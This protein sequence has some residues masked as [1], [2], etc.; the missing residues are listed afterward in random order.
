MLKNKIGILT[1]TF[2]SFLLGNSCVD[3]HLNMFKRPITYLEFSSSTS[4]LEVLAHKYKESVFIFWGN[5]NHPITYADNEIHLTEE[6]TPE[7][8]Q[9]LGECEHID[10][11]FINI[12]KYLSNEQWLKS[13][14]L[15][16]EHVFIEIETNKALQTLLI[17]FGFNEINKQEAK[18]TYYKYNKI[19]FLKRTQWLEPASLSNSIREIKSSYTEKFLIKKYAQYPKPINWLSGINLMTFKMLKGTYPT[20]DM[21]S[22]EMAKTYDIHHLDWMPNNIIVRGKHMQ[23]IDTDDSNQEA[24]TVRTTIMLALMLLLAKE[25]NTT[26]VRYLFELILFYCRIAIHPEVMTYRKLLLA[27]KA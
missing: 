16:A 10:V 23:L 21:L 15:L 7:A 14:S 19:T 6:V 8:I 27:T 24:K 4:H 1:L 20:P 22:S 25:T 26:N 12:E 13:V 3:N 18:A 9:H 17:R 5:I 11:V 2:S